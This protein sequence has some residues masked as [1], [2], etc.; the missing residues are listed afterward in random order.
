LWSGDGTRILFHRPGSASDVT[1]VWVMKHD[2]SE[3]RRVAELR[4]RF[5]L[6]FSAL[7]RNDQLAWVQVRRGR[8]ELWLAELPR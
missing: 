6:S 2:G 1:E 8:Q 5:S 4:S 3:Q 7:S